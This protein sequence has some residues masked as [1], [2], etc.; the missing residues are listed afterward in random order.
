MLTRFASIPLLAGMLLLTGCHSHHY[1][2]RDDG[3]RD[4]NRHKH[5]RRHDHRDSNDDRRYN[6]RYHR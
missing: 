4:N 5:D 6:G 3:Y 1:D 2:D